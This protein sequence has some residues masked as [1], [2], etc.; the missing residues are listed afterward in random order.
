MVKTYLEVT[1]DVVKEGNARIAKKKKRIK[2][3]LCFAASVVITGAVAAVFSVNRQPKPPINTDLSVQ[4]ATSATDAQTTQ[5]NKDA[6]MLPVL[7]DTQDGTTLHLRTLIR[8]PE[9]QTVEK[10][11]APV[12]GQHIVTYPLQD[13]I[14]T[15]AGEDVTYCIRFHVLMDYSQMTANE[16]EAFYQKESERMRDDRVGMTVEVFTDADGKKQVTFCALMW[17]PSFLDDF[18]DNPDYGYIISLY[19]E[20]SCIK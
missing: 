9:T 11:K 18:P 12:A 10:Y 1:Q 7:T 14:R 13:V 2:T 6:A 4:D 17:D 16:L 15:H 19:D 5:A 3:I 20:E 8:A